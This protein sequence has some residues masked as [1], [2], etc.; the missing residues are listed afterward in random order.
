M[1]ESVESTAVEGKSAR[2]MPKNLLVGSLAVNRI[3]YIGFY[4]DFFRNF[5]KMCWTINVMEDIRRGCRRKE[6]RE[7]VGRRPKSAGL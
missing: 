2:R 3:Y 4:I 7:S 5:S 1:L 6:R